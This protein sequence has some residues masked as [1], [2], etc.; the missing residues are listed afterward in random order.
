MARDM[1][2]VSEESNESNEYS[3]ECYD[4]RSGQHRDR[5]LVKAAR[6]EE[7][8]E[9]KQNTIYTKVPISECIRVT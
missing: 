2:N 9:F 6:N 1:L 5:N 8:V 7:V 3:E 4:D